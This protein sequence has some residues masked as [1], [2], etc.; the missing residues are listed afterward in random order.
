VD[1]LDLMDWTFVVADFD[2]SW[3]EQI[4]TEPTTGVTAR[5]AL[6][7]RNGSASIV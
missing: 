6:R 5:W 3:L 1:I 7:E 4:R 2:A